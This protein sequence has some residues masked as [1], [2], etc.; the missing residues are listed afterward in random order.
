MLRAHILDH[1]YRA[2]SKLE[3]A[4]LSQL[5]TPPPRT[6]FPTAAHF[7]DLQTAPPTGDKMFKCL[8]LRDVLSNQVLPSF[9]SL[10]FTC[11]PS[12]LSPELHP[13]PLSRLLLHGT[14]RQLGQDGEASSLGSH[15]VCNSSV[16]RQL[17]PVSHCCISGTRDHGAGAREGTAEGNVLA[18]RRWNS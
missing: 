12:P 15:C 3:M 5:S 9:P 14:L 6:C 2:E 18:E 8:R 17:P 4:W 10:P 1:K 16:S 13:Q 11:P 7:L